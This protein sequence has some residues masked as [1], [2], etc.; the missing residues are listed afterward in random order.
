MVSTGGLVA[1][2]A[3]GVNPGQRQTLNQVS[4]RKLQSAG[5]GHI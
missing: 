5:D 2:Q 4:A 3:A 1:S